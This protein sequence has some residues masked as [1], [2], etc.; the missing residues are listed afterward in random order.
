MAEPA[1]HIAGLSKQFGGLPAVSDVSL[2]IMPGERHLLLG[3]N[4]AGKTTLFNLI[5]GDLA[6]TL[7]SIRLFGAELV[8]LPPRKRTAFGLARTYQI[9][10]LF[11]HETICRN[12]M[13]A[14]NGLKAGKWGTWRAF[15][16]NR[17]LRAEAMAILDRVRLADLADRPVSQTA[18]GDRRRLE[19]AMAL[20]LSPRVLLLDEPLAGLSRDE[21]VT[22]QDLLAN[23]PPD[24]TV[25]LIEHDMD[26]AL[27]FAERITLLHH[28]RVV[29]TGSRAEIAA[30]PRTR[31]V[32]LG[33]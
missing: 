17:A 25:V 23:L 24:V 14:L 32:Y 10:T 1:L 15:E 8:G 5:C 13:L 11:P 12:V 2:A 28:G 26:V 7:G 27:A 3:P 9:L 19:I 22:V 33:A 18:Y 6:P 21:R 29:A 4:G 31:E 16:A 20:A 30:D